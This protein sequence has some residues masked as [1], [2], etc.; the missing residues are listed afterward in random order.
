MELTIKYLLYYSTSLGIYETEEYSAG[1]RF[2]AALTLAKHWLAFT[3]HPEN[4][5]ILHANGFDAFSDPE[6][7][8]SYT[9][10]RLCQR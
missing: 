3:T 7:E 6:E 4:E 8:L 5:D 1:I 9:F 10:L 2:A